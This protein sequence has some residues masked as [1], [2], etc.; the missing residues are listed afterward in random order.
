MRLACSLACSN[1][2][3]LS[4]WLS[5]YMIG[6]HF[7]NPC[8]GNFVALWCPVR[9]AFTSHYNKAP[10]KHHPHCGKPNS[11]AENILFI[12]I[13]QTMFINSYTCPVALQFQFHT[14]FLGRCLIIMGQT[15]TS[16]T[17]L[18]SYFAIV[19]CPAIHAL[20][21][22]WRMSGGLPDLNFLSQRCVQQTYNYC[23]LFAARFV[24]LSYLQVVSNIP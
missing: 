8:C 10:N 2:V 4:Q 24:V 23:S 3:L 20:P 14:M 12:Y 11:I 7:Y 13:P 9:N 1:I 6:L 17:P 16:S 22:R 21:T 18:I 19:S 15:W 5:N